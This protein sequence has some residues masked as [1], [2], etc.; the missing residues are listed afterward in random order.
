[1]PALREAEF[2][3]YLNYE[4]SANRRVPE[5][6]RDEMARYCFRAGEHLIRMYE[7]KSE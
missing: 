2:D 5:A 7:G 1:M 4:T 3:G 6:L